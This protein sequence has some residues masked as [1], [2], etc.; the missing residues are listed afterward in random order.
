MSKYICMECTYSVPKWEGKCPGCQSWN[1]FVLEDD[2][3][4][5]EK[6]KKVT[7]KKIIEL[8][9]SCLQ[10]TTTG[11][12]EIDRV[13]GGG[14]I[15]GSLILLA[16]HPGSGKSTLITEIIRCLSGKRILYTSGE[17]S[18]KQVGGRFK[19]LSVGN[20]NLYIACESKWENIKYLIDDLKPDLL[21]IDSIQ[22]TYSEEIQSSP[23]TVTQ[24][25][26]V[27]YRLM[28]DV[29]TNDL[30]TFVIGHITKEGGVA[31]P[32]I[33]EHMVDTV[34]H[35]EGD[36]DSQLR[37][38]RSS[39]NRFGLNNEIG[40]LEMSSRG[41]SE[42]K[43]F[44]S[45]VDVRE[46]NKIG[47][48]FTSVLEGSRNFLVEVQSLVSKYD[49]QSPRKFCEGVDYSRV[50]LISAV[51][52]KY[53]NTKLSSRDLFL[54]VT[55]GL[56]IQK[57]ES[58]LAIVASLLSSYKERKLP[59]DCV[60]IGEIGLSGE[61]RKTQKLNERLRNFFQMGVKKAF[62]P[63]GNMGSLKAT[64]LEVMPLKRV[65]DLNSFF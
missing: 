51:M 32:K 46:S 20:E 61:V 65:E 47:S 14:L 12:N 63:E 24:V 4:Q 60:F 29:K 42:I 18:E 2:H 53:L 23:G 54:N 15:K 43:G 37:I 30:T 55:N 40:V 22:T 62:I 7:A 64:P 26:E 1:S 27:T 35:L 58:D 19:R 10:R 39:K 36:S 41:L 5:K 49:S 3:K 34:L 45:E 56:R 28:S 11:N 48:A 13:L 44:E 59:M 57:G 50:V 16:G 31:G 6:T 21:I 33:L 25:K 8:E 9:V 52:E 38:L 17:E